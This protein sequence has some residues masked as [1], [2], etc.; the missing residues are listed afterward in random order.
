[1]NNQKSEPFKIGLCMA[2]AVSAGAYTAGVMDYLIEALDEWE[3]QKK[4]HPQFRPGGTNI[5]VWKAQ[6]QV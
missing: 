4:E 1:M 3:K 5:E 6:G 2:G